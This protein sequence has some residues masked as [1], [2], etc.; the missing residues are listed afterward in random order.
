GEQVVPQRVKLVL[1]LAFTLIIAPAVLPLL[2]PV[3]PFPTEM[4]LTEVIAGLLLGFGIRLFIFVLQIA[5][6]IAAQATT[7][8]QMFGGIGP[9]PQ[10]IIGNVLIIAGL[11]AAVSAGLHIRTAELLIFSYTPL[12]AGAFPLASDVAQ[13][14]I[15]QISRAFSLGFSLAAPFVIASVLYNVALGF[16]NR[17]MP[18]LAVSFVGAPALTLGGL[19][20]LALSA[21]FL[22]A[23][24]L[25]LLNAHLANPF[26]PTP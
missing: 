20:L 11:A 4:F 19:A 6:A 22:I 2:P 12:P 14:G 25:Q 15:A 1:A 3:D 13:L 16:I 5:G 21:P 17:A 8:S 7:L 9:E 18:Q 23:L 24:W 26:G 10:P